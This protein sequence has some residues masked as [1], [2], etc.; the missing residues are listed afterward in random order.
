MSRKRNFR[1]NKPEQ[2]DTVVLEERNE[3]N[4]EG[5]CIVC[6]AS[7]THPLTDMCGPCTFGEADTIGGN[8]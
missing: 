7:P 2:T 8:W 6:G 3:P 4:W 1:H 5:Q